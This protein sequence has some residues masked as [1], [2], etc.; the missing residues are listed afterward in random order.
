[1]LRRGE[2]SV[3]LPIACNDE[4]RT[5]MT[6][7]ETD[8][9]LLNQIIGAPS[10]SPLAE[11]R[12][13]RPDILRH[14]QG[15]HEVLLSP[16]DPGGLSLAERAMVA[17]VVATLSGHAALTAHYQALVAA[18]GEPSAG[19]RRAAILAHAERLTTAPG[20]ATKQH[21]AML[22]AVGLS[23]RDIVA[24]AQLVAFVAYQVRAAVGLSLLA[25]EKAA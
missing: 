11:L 22:D 24:L 13:Q 23:A 8:G 16:D 1:M 6:P 3:S 15:S 19:A 18:R 17:R 4:R 21:L 5:E 20:T 12:A 2:E 7:S 9:D 25:R 10:G 14:T